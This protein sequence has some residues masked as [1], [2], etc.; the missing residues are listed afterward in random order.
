MRLIDANLASIFFSSPRKPTRTE[1]SPMRI[2][3]ASTKKDWGGG[4]QLL[5]H[6]IAGIVDAGHEVGLASRRDSGIAGWARNFRLPF[7][8][9]LPGRGKSPRSLWT[10]RSWLRQHAFDALVLNDPHAI[11]SGGLAAWRLPL[12]RI[13]IR[14]TSFPVHSAWKHRTLVDHLV[15]VSQAAQAECTKVGIPAAMT[16]V[17][18]GGLPEPRIDL[19]QVHELRA[20]FAHAAS[21]QARHLL[22]VGSL[23]DVKGFDVTIRA[24]ADGV[25]QG[26]NWHLWI[27]G[28]GEEL[29]ALSALAAELDVVDRVHWLGFRRDIVALLT[30]ADLFVSASYSEGLPLVLVEAMQAGCP[31][32]STP[33][34]G[35]VEALDVDASHHSPRAEIF[36]P[37]DHAALAAAIERSLKPSILQQQ[38]S[39]NAKAWTAA[40]FSIPQMAERHLALYTRLLRQ[41]PVAVPAA[42]RAA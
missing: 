27:A 7:T 33:V 36:P 29:N 19:A 18:Y 15:C 16:S 26:R 30:A 10:L 22:G 12:L 34:G 28:Q 1:H 20:M 3:F 9:E 41:N 6:L 32:I 11:T 38:R 39:E 24:L 42:R 23:L 37:G 31:I 8:L 4:E 35:C 14:H 2:A 25:R 40:N 13:G 17:I 21:G 5:T